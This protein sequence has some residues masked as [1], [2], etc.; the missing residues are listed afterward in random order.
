M[1]KD[2][3]A[4]PIHWKN[5]ERSSYHRDGCYA[6]LV[7]LQDH[8][9]RGSGSGEPRKNLSLLGYRMSRR[10]PQAC[11]QD[12]QCEVCNDCVR[13]EALTKTGGPTLVAT[14]ANE[15]RAVEPQR[16]EILV[17]PILG[18]SAVFAPSVRPFK[19]S[20]PLL[21]WSRSK[22]MA[23]SLDAPERRVIRLDQH[24][25]PHCT[26]VGVRL[27]IVRHVPERPV[28]CEIAKP[29]LM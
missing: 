8:F 24:G 22:E 9:T 26:H 2:S 17:P 13:A 4:S 1:F 20:W 6:Q 28:N 7:F 23:A 15:L 12:S 19:Y 29:L 14:I 5:N 16:C 11:P 25:I 18:H 10:S 27:A 21:R 3:H